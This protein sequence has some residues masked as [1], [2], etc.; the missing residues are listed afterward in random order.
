MADETKE[1]GE[2]SSANAGRP[3]SRTE[4][5]N[6]DYSTEPLGARIK[7]IGIGGAG[8]NAVNNMIRSG[9]KGVEFITAN[10]DGQSLRSSLSDTRL[11]P[12]GLQTTSGLGAGASPEVGQAAAKE[13]A[14]EIRKVLEGADMVFVTAGL[15]GGSGTGGAPIVAQIARELGA[16]TVGVVT[17]P[18][19]FEGKKRMTNADS[20]WQNLKREVDTLITIPN[21]RLLSIAGRNTTCSTASEELMTCCSRP[22]REFPI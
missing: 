13:S 12:F 4:S 16:L 11:Q 17:K 1:S 10:T 7:V 14:D 6:R 2:K 3:G 18:F 21:Q 19:L 22:S 20:G 15:G 8:G 5:S 9:L